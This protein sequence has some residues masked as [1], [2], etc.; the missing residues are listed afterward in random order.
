MKYPWNYRFRWGGMYI[1]TVPIARPQRY[2]SPIS[3]GP[4]EVRGFLDRANYMLDIASKSLGDVTLDD[5]DK[6]G[7]RRFIKRVPLGV[8]LVIAP[9]KSVPSSIFPFITHKN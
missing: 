7:V 1:T 4:G 2:E 3:Q 5:T 9:W 6:P 8:I